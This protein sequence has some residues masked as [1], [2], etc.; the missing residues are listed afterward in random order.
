MAD[1][2]EDAPVVDAAPAAP[3]APAKSGSPLDRAL[4]AEG[5]TGKLAD[6]A[7]SIYTQESTAG[8]DTATSDAG[9]VG[10]M[11]LRPDTF[12]R[13]ADKGWSIDDPEHNARAA[14][15]Y[16]K[17]LSDKTGGDPKLI[18]VGYYG[19]EGAIP[20]AKAG[21]AVRDP[22]NPNAPDTLQYADQV[23]SRVPKTEAKAAP[24]DEENWWTAAPVVAADTGSTPSGDEQQEPTRA[25]EDLRGIG[26]GARSVAQGAASP[27]TFFGDTLNK[28]INLGIRGVNALTGAQIPQLSM[29]SQA[30]SNALTGVGLPQPQTATERVLG[31]IQGGAAGALTGAG[32]YG[33]LSN[34]AGNPLARNALA[35]F[36]DRPVIQAGSAAAGAGAAGVTREEGGGPLAQ[37]AAGLA[38]GFAPSAGIAAGAGATRNALRGSADNIPAMQER[39]KTFEEA[40]STRPS[41]GQVTGNRTAQATESLL[42][43]TPGGAGQLA[44]RAEQQAEEIGN[45]A[46]KIADD[47][48]PNATPS[49]AGRTI[50]RGLSGPGGFVDRFKQGQKALYDKLDPYFRYTDGSSKSVKLPNTIK[51]LESLNPTIPGAPSTSKFFQNSEMQAIKD[52]VLEDVGSV[53]A[54][55]Q[56][57]NIQASTSLVKKAFRPADL[58]EMF[59]AYGGDNLPYEAVKKMRSLVGEK[60]ENYSLASS[61]PRSKWKSLYAALSEDL[62]GAAKSIGDPD[63]VK[64]MQ[65]ANAFTR[66][67]HA[68]IDDVLD[69]VAKQD[70]PE[71]VF[72]S[73]VNPADMQAG[74]TKIGSI[75]K[76]LTPAER[77]VVKSAFIRRMGQ[78]SA[79]Q[80]G[81]EGERFSTQTFLTNWNKMSPQAK[82]VMF[83]GQDGKLRVG[84][85]QIA[86]AADSIKSG[87]KVF[88]NPS[89]TS[90]S[91][92]LI[93]LA[94]G[95]ASAV[96]SGRYL[97]A[98]TLLSGAAGANLGARLFTYQP[99]VQ[100][101]AKS[102]KLSP[103]ALP[104]A[105][106]ALQRSMQ[107]APDDVREEADR[108]IQSVTGTP[109]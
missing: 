104:V 76:S 67:G 98:A 99:F 22:R 38:G 109:K 41:V 66:A 50:E 14:V 102:T 81:A 92:A 77:D 4:K 47:L 87:S 68:R 17:S 90:H 103:A 55:G 86:K 29:P 1:W 56:R 54:F 12:K 62:D 108:Y 89:G 33:Q 57:P 15:R 75:M 61:V 3:A 6:V 78:A 84:L 100:W 19:G 95:T 5:V 88:S 45:Q 8:R 93:G 64:A 51:A 7:R 96:A 10:G 106:G 60:L 80:Q 39:M 72:K 31:D 11:Q 94:A 44:K 18:S 63:A 58:Q 52:A 71:K 37:M 13:F 27:L 85:E 23:T 105:V 79:G 43:K 21:I 70:I 49:V 91:T 97:T 74:A 26:L 42:S 59:K 2:W 35:Q 69:K 36:A 24:K 73:A 34:V 101:L 107:T 53:E 65:R 82:S 25:Q 9:A 40:G 48:S 28:G 16:I 32:L 20:K 46:T 30:V 83:S